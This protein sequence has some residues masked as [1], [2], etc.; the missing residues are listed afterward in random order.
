MVCPAVPSDT[1]VAVVGSHLP[2]HTCPS[3]GGV[4][5]GT[6]LLGYVWES[7]WTFADCATR[8]RDGGDPRGVCFIALNV[9]Q[10]VRKKFSN[11]LLCNLTLKLFFV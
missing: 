10:P 6:P 4:R 1:E 5:F 2:P 7:P 3:F 11:F 8:V 9:R